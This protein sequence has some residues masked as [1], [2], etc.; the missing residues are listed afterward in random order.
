MPSTSKTKAWIIAARPQTL[1]AGISPVIVGTALAIHDGVFSLGPAFAALIGALLIQIGTNLANDYYDGIKGTDDIDKKGFTRATSSGILSAEQVKKAMYLTYF[2]SI[3][4]GL[5]LVYIGGIP[6]LLIGVISI[7][8][9]IAYTGGP[10]PFGYYGLGDFFVF[11][12]FGVIAVMG[13]YYV[14][15]VSF[16]SVFMP[17][18][19]PSDTISWISFFVSL[20]MA[21]LTTSI[22]VVNNIRDIEADSKAGKKTLAVIIGDKLSRIEF[23]LLIG[24]SYIIPIY[25]IKNFGIS[26]L[27]PLLT[28]PYAIYILYIVSTKKN[29]GHLNLALKHTGKLL[30]LFAVLFSL[31]IIL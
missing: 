4:V 15:A 11:I 14:Q 26:S 7:L 19:I 23:L 22:L 24:M 13:T 25:L 20:P 1:P 31:G 16:L 6:I 18:W 9:G 17:F 8:S 21:G 5:Y 30:F 2:M 3:L 27:L 10:Y 28:I 12:F 29:G